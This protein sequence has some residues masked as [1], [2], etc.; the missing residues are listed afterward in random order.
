MT[1]VAAD[2]PTLA[3]TRSRIKDGEVIDGVLWA[4]Y[5]PAADSAA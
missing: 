3:G 5:R 1:G 2:L 4:C